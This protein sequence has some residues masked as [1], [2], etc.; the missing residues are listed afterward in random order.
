MCRNGRYTERGIK[1][2]HGYGAEFFRIEPEFAVKIDRS[3]GPLG[4]L[5]EPPSIVAKA[6]DHVER[7]GRR[8]RSWQ[9]GVAA[10]HRCRADRPARRPDGH[11]T[12]PRRP[13]AR[14]ATRTGRSPRSCRRSAEIAS[15]RPRRSA[16][17]A[18]RR[19]D[20]M[21]RRPDVVRACSARRP[22]SRNRLPA[23][24]DRP[25]H[26]LEVDIGGSTAPPCSTTT[27]SSA[28]ST[29]IVRTTRWRPTRWRVPTRNGSTRLITRRVPLARFA[30]SARASVRAT[31]RSSS[32]S[33]C[34]LSAKRVTLHDL[35]DRIEDYALIG[36]CETAALVGRNGSID[37]L[38]WPRFD[39]DAC[40]A[41]LLGT[42]RARPLADRAAR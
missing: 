19:C 29:P 17:L 18:A 40:F 38:C 4:V 33:R 3:L 35:A 21:H 8:S 20:G 24:R 13:R 6:W 12:R 30:R 39:S 32:I 5:M 10:R 23:R 34:P 15:S 36:D 28:P 16:T 2:R 37:W 22:P 9:A 14:P 11:A 25:G 26:A 42:R 41:A 7:I 31:S 27:R 1:E